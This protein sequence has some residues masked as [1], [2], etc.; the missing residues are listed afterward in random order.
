L[1]TVCCEAQHAIA[2]MSWAYVGEGRGA[3]SMSPTYNFVG[4]GC[5]NFDREVAT[6]YYG[7]KVR[8]CCLVLVGLLLL[9][10]LVYFMMLLTGTTIPT[11]TPVPST[12]SLQTTSTPFNC[13]VGGLESM[14]QTQWCCQHY[15]VGCT[16]QPPPT[17]APAPPP[18]PP[19]LPPTTS[20]HL[21]PVPVPAP[22]PAVAS[23]PVPARPAAT[24]LPFDCNADF[25]DCYHCLVQR[26]SIGKRAWCCAHA[27]RGCPT[28][29]P[30]TPPLKTSLPFDCNAGFAN[31]KAGWSRGKKG[32]CCTHANRGCPSATAT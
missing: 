23:L 20:P 1:Q 15:G 2:N 21:L 7:W 27:H 29:A 12:T 3:Y 31:W 4:E 8:K 9:P 22:A 32:W 18:P 19:P 11:L 16:T 24:S 17:A 13:G 6:T 14:S 26:W 28:V 25:I 10:L 30:T 5:G